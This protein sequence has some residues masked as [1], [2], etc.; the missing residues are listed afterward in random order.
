MNSVVIIA[1]VALVAFQGA[2]A[3]DL[4]TGTGALFTG[5]GGTHLILASGAAGT[6]G[7]VA[8][9][10]GAAL[11]LKAAALLALR[12]SRGKRAT[13]N[14][15]DLAFVTIAAAEPQACDRRLICDLATGQVPKSENDVI[16]KLFDGKKA[17]V[18][19]AKFDFDTAAEVGKALKNVDAC[20]I[21]YSCPFKGEQII[22]LIN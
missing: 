22:K 4:I 6:V 15:L 21:R 14:E 20:E 12:E 3:T 17:D 16:V 2:E 8:A 10:G 9:V 11:L 19:S 1:V 13:E 5:T 7:A 18:T